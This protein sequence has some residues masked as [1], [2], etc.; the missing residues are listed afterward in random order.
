MQITKKWTDEELAD[1]NDGSAACARDSKFWEV[2]PV[3]FNALICE[4]QAWRRENPS[5]V[6]VSGPNM[7][8]ARQ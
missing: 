1:A 6:F 4:V 5:K 8:L 7:I 3:S 2:S